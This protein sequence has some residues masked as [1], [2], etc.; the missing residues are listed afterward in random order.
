VKR[1]LAAFL[2]RRIDCECFWGTKVLHVDLDSLSFRLKTES[3]RKTCFQSTL[4][5]L[6]RVIL[7]TP[8]NNLALSE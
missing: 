1:S 2:A 4:V 5:A 8:N 3:L 7:V 6:S